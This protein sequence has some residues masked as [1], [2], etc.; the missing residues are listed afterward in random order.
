MRITKA[1]SWLFNRAL[2]QAER[3]IILQIISLDRRTVKGPRPRS[4][5]ALF[6]MIFQ[7]RR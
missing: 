6:Q 2:A 1:L 5:M 3:D 4:Q 7:S